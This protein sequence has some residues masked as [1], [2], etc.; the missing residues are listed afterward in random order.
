M[1]ELPLQLELPGLQQVGLEVGGGAVIGGVIG[2]AA[3]KVAKL[4]AILVGIELALFKFLETRGILEVNW[5]AI[6]G[7]AGNVSSA[8]GET[9]GAQP[10]GWVMSLLSALPVSAGFT[11]GFLVGFR[12]G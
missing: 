8:A 5:S 10:P 12:K 4:I 11:G 9:A 6:S 7:T 1:I 2:F 3:K